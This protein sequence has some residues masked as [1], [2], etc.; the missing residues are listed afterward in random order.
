[1]TS[2]I[3]STGHAVSQGANQKQ[4]VERQQALVDFGLL[5]GTM[6][7]WK[8]LAKPPTWWDERLALIM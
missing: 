2:E 7:C 4:Y 5:F 8:F 1:M 3:G 6:T